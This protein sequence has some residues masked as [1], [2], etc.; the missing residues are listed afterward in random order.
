M[1]DLKT[2]VFH[3]PKGQFDPKQAIGKPIRNEEKDLVVG[4]IIDFRI[5]DEDDLVYFIC[6]I[7]DDK[8]YERFIQAGTMKP[9]TLEQFKEASNK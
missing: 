5:D 7:T 4:E 2:L 1:N 9:E 3:A 6:K 8:E